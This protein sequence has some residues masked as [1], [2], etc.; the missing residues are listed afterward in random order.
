M[1]YALLLLAFA[2]LSG[3]ISTQATVLD[4]ETRPE[5]AADSVRVYRTAE[6]IKC[7][8]AEVAIIHAQ[9][10]ANF[11]N[12]NQM[13]NAA[14]KKAGK[15]GANGVVLGNINEPSAGAKVAGAIFGVS[16]DRRGELLAVFVY[17][18]CR[19][20]APMTEEEPAAVDSTDSGN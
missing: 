13:I 11:T 18:P 9:G 2:V 19:P 16:P 1:R 12:E 8:Y 3:C 17:D 20:L 4:P 15:V 14:K 5:I 7:E 6:S 10:G